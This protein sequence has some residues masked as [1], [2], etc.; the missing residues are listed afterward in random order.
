MGTSGRLLQS[1]VLDPLH[2]TRP[3]QPGQG[4]VQGSE[5]HVGELPELVAQPLP[6]LVSVHGLALEQTQD[7]ELEHYRTPPSTEK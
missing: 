4:G 1:R 7:G 6:D 3:L 5:R 2:R